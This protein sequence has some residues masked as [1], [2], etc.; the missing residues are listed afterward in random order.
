[1]RG[2]HIFGDGL[3]GLREAKKIDD[4]RPK[5]DVPPGPIKNDSSLIFFFFFFL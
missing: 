4:C 5:I 2:E 3:G 1:M